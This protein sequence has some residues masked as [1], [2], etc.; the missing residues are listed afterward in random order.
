[1]TRLSGLST[2]RGHARLAGVGLGIG[3]GREELAALASSVTL[4]IAARIFVCMYMH[5]RYGWGGGAEG[6]SGMAVEGG[7]LRVW[8]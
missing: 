3:R 8:M 4:K 5:G 1:M 2:P 7:V 6:V